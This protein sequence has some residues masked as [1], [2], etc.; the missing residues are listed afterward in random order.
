MS[1]VF[2][3]TPEDVETLTAL[4]RD[5]EWWADREAET[6]REALA[7]TEVAVGVESNG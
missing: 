1:T 5:Y 6:V 2:D 3:L 7:E 4:Y